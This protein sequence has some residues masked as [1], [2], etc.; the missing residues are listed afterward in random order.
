ME[1]REEILERTRQER[2]RRRQKKLEEENAVV[3][4]AAWRAYA[5]R[6][7]AQQEIRVAWLGK[8]GADSVLHQ[9]HEGDDWKE[10]K[11]CV[12]EFCYFAHPDVWSDVGEL[13]R[14]CE[15]LQRGRVF[16]SPDVRLFENNF[17]LSIRDVFQLVI[18]ALAS[19]RDRFKSSLERPAVNLEWSDLSL[20]GAEER[21][22]VQLFRFAMNALTSSSMNIEARKI[23]LGYKYRSF[24]GQGSKGSLFLHLAQLLE[25]GC[26]RDGT[27][28]RTSAAGT[29]VTHC[30]V[31]FLGCFGT[32]YSY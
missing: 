32:W 24:Q 7:I 19:H 11:K 16:Q 22:F 1:S 3:I 21:V 18:T 10:R 30:L 23:M 14:L 12:S 8:Y 9:I 26:P 2:E 5:A 27:V 25:T 20:H 15:A 29:L 4:Q 31:S 28:G 13:G 6:Q 17:I